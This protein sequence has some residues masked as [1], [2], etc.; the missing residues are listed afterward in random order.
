MYTRE[1]PW[2][3]DELDPQDHMKDQEM[4]Q[5]MQGLCI[6]VKLHKTGHKY[7]WY[8]WI[9][10]V[11]NIFINNYMGVARIYLESIGKPLFHK[12]PLFLDRKNKKTGY[13]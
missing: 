10:T 9:S 4:F 2:G 1:D 12:T 3:Y 6:T 11:D 8:L 5:V 7:T 13:S